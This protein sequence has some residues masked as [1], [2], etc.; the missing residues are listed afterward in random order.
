MKKIVFVTYHP[1]MLTNWIMKLKP[2]MNGCEIYV[3][4]ISKLHGFTQKE[5]PGISLYDVSYNS[6]K[7]NLLL[8]SSLQPDIVVF[9]S[10][11]SLWE[12]T[13]KRICRLSNTRQVYLEHGL[14]S[15]DTLHFRTKK[16]KYEF[17]QMLKRQIYFWR[18]EIG[19]IIRA[20]NICQEWIA[21][22]DFYLKGIFRTTPFEHYFIYS[23]RS[24]DKYSSIFDLKKEDNT[25]FIGYPIFND[26]NQKR[27][28]QVNDSET[29]REV[30]YVH[31]PLISDGY[32]SI[33]YEEE[34]EWLLRIKDV[35]KDKYDN[36]TILLHPR[37]NL[38][39]YKARFEGTGIVVIQSPNNYQ[40]FAQSA[41][42]IGHY[43]TALLY[44][45]YF[46][47]PTAILNYPTVQMD[48]TFL[49]CF[50]YYSKVEEL[51]DTDFKVRAGTRTY[52]LGEINTYENI[53][54]KI[55]NYIQ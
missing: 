21:F 38:N 48:D 34:K 52:F 11:R 55:I 7:Q 32:A 46:E 25:T 43:S 24:F 16:L 50:D 9:L 33:T 19:C 6:F 30:L 3:I 1:S 42:V 27:L 28:S 35:L 8:L 18:N 4:H 31:Q 54:K 5:I 12:Y 39:E 44:A 10:F 40:V 22:V 17:V 36:L 13:L 2:Y 23:Q 49:E 53:A 26:E 37:S 51:A 41:L 45:L 14:F 20:D 15:Q 29:T 47:K